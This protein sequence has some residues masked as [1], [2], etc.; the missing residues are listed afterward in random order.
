VALTRGNAPNVDVLVSSSDGSRL[1]ALQVKTRRDARVENKKAPERS[2]CEWEVKRFDVKKYNSFLFC[3]VDLER[4]D[5]YI[6][7]PVDVAAWVDR[8]A[9]NRPFFWIDDKDA[10]KYKNKWDRIEERIRPHSSDAA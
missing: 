7:P 9:S 4:S 8:D 10:E 1:L 5:V 3:F 2:R 6:V